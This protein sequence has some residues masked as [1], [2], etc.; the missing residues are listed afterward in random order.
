MENVQVFAWFY[1]F[2]FLKTI[3]FQSTEEIF[4]D[5]TTWKTYIFR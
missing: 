3:F 2:F 5:Y 1:S 4:L